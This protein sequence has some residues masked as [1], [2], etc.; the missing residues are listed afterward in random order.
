MISIVNTIFNLYTVDNKNSFKKK[1]H[2]KF[3]TVS[4]FNSI[5]F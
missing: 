4:Y 1:Q 2:Q 3:D 5:F